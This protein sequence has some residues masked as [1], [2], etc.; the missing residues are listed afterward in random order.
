MPKIKARKSSRPSPILSARLVRRSTNGAQ[1][2]DPVGG[3][4][5]GE[6]RSELR[7]AAR[8][9]VVNKITETLRR[10]LPVPE[11]GGLSLVEIQNMAVRFEER[12][13][14]AATSQYDYM[15]KIALKMLSF[16][17]LHNRNNAQAVPNQNPPSPGNGEGETAA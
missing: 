4:G 14:T 15:R 17:I 13:Y 9:R 3:G 16:E 2:A 11:E 8:G 1:G 5:G 6:W 12:M 10:Y 7:P